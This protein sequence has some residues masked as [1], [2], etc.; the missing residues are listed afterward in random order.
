MEKRERERE[1]EKD[2]IHKYIKH[3]KLMVYIKYNK[4][5]FLLCFVQG[6]AHFLISSTSVTYEVPS[7]QKR[8]NF[9]ARCLTARQQGEDVPNRTEFTRT[10]DDD[11][12]DDDDDV[13]RLLVPI[14]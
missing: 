2:Q 3:H 12:D 5:S 8:R 1:R 13:S 7:E 14:R 4:F 6:A 11:D 9:F 10:D